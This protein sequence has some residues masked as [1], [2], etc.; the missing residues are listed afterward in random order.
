MLARNDRQQV[1]N[2]GAVNMEAAGRAATFNKRK[3][4]TFLW[5]RRAA[6]L[7]L[8]LK[9]ADESFVHFDGLATAAH[10]RDKAASPH[11]FANTM[12]Q[13]PC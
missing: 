6:P 5:R 7:G 13:E 4:T 9:A 8:A 3:D 11:G 1:A 10:R 12:G 2:A